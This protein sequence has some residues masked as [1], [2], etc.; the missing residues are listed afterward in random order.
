MS[1]L[2]NSQPL[3]L[4]LFIERSK[5][6]WPILVRHIKS[7]AITWG[8]LIALYGVVHANYRLCINETPS[9]PYTLFLICLNDTVETGGLIAFKWHQRQ[10]LS[11]GISRS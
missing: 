10:S 5:S 4:D 8:L 11:R 7:H 3:T 2:N 1:T 9:L 6:F